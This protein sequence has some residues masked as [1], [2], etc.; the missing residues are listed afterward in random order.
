MIQFN[1]ET[2][3]SLNNEEK[4]K[5][6]ISKCI[7][8]YNFT[9]GEINFIFCN[10]KY[11]YK[12]NTEFLKHHTFTDIISFDYTLGKLLSADIFI[13]IERVKENAKKYTQTFDNELY[14]VLIHG[15]LH[16]VGYTDKKEEEK[17][18][19]RKQE[20]KCVELLHTK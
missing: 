6:W 13:S 8:N 20:N 2:N 9:E 7:K 15:I 18:E 1:Y 16:C 19:M 11:L 17:K 5:N 14:K 3:F 10:D 12:L 4:L